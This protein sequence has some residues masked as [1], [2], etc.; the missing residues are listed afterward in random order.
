VSPIPAIL[1]A[2]VI[3][4]L[5]GGVILTLVTMVGCIAQAVL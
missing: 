5:A 3:G 2:A 1:T 4:T